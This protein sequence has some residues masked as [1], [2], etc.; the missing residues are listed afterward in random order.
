MKKSL[1]FKKINLDCILMIGILQS[2][3]DFSQAKVVNFY[4]WAD[5]IGDDTIENF[6]EE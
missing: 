2:F 6:Q 1:K 5:Y 3:T 4:N